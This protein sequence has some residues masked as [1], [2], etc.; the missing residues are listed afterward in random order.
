MEEH[1]FEDKQV[2]YTKLYIVGHDFFSL[3]RTS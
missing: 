3:M 2:N 1:I